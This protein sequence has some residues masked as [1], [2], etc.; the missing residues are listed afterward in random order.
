MTPKHQLHYNTIDHRILI[1]RYEFETLMKTTCDYFH[2]L[3]EY[4]EYIIR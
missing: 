1:F 4:V 2:L 3:L